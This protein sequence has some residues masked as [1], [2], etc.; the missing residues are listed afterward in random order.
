MAERV[1]KLLPVTAAQT[2]ALR[3]RFLGDPSPRYHRKKS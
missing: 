1:D 3:W 2:N